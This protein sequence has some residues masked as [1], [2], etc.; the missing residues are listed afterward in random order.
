MKFVFKE[1]A[2]V[3]IYLSNGNKINGK[4]D[5]VSG[6]YVGKREKRPDREGLLKVYVNYSHISRVY[7]G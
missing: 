7:T 6:E 1:G 2:E 4:V 3:E 5:V